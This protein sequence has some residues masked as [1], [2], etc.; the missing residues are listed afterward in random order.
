MNQMLTKMSKKCTQKEKRQK[1]GM[2][3]QKFVN[4]V[5]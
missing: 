5:D 3:A 4:I 2:S 1:G